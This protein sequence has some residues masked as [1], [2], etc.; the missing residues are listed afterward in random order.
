MYR[1]YYSHITDPTVGRR[2]TSRILENRATL[3]H[4]R[5]T[6]TPILA[7]FLVGRRHF[8]RS[9]KVKS[10]VDRSADFFGICHRLSVGP[11]FWRNLHHDIGRRLPDQRAS[12]GRRSPDGRSM[13]FYQRIVGRLTPKSAVIRAMVARLSADHKMWFVFFYN[14][15]VCI[16]IMYENKSNINAI[17]RFIS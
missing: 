7:E 9:T 11:T 17:L 15:H 8:C 5:P 14:V 16:Y 1:W 3:A 13:S 2:L 4:C 10:F 6:S 12:I